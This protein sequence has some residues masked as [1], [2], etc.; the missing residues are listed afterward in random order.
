MSWEPGK[1]TVDY[2]I[3]KERLE[4]IDAGWAQRNAWSILGRARRRLETA[5]SA[6]AHDDLE[7]AYANAYDSYRMCAEALL[8]AQAL[9]GTGGR[10]ATHVTIEDAVSSQFAD[11]LPT[12]SKPVF[13]NFRK[14][15]QSAQYFDPAR[16]EIT[17][18]DAR[19]AIETTTR[20]VTTTR[21][22]L[23][24]GRLSVYD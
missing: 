12:F 21:Q 22:L 2:L 13:E 15:R 24:S 3:D 9:R 5:R 11:E 14:T 7:G 6:L 10:E 23:E 19:S 16:P 18:E 8:A 1:S 20:T 17:A 4:R